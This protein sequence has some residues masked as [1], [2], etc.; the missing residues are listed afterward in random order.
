MLYHRC[1]QYSCGLGLRLRSTE[2]VVDIET[3]DRYTG[4]APHARCGTLNSLSLASSRQPSSAGIYE[5]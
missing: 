2:Y 4:S 3:V 1:I 5:G